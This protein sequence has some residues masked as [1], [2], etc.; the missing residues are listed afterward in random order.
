MINDIIAGIGLTSLA[1]GLWLQFGLPW[2][3][4]A[5]GSLLVVAVSV[6]VLRK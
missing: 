5:V 3:L 2:A 1:A 6:A 4:I